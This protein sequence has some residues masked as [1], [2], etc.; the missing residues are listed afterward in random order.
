MCLRTPSSDKGRTLIYPQGMCGKVFYIPPEILENSEAFDPFAVDVWSMG[1]ILFMMLVGSPP[2]EKPSESDRAFRWVTGGKLR[3][4]LY[5]W[6][7]DLSDEAIDLLE[8]ML[9]VNLHDRITV[10][11]IQN[12]PWMKNLSSLSF[13]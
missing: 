1:V 3:K 8:R 13:Q 9:T 7:R 12:H 5:F 2:F 10:S 4:L 11:D 6:E